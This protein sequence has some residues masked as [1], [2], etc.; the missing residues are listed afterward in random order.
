MRTAG[1][2]ATRG[3]LSAA[4]ALAYSYPQANL[5]EDWHADYG[6]SIDSTLNSYSGLAPAPTLSGTVQHVPIWLGIRTGAALGGGLYNLSLD[7]G[8]TFPI[9]NQTLPGGGTVTV[10]GT[11]MVVTFPA[12]TYT[13]GAVYTSR[14]SSWV[15]RK[16]AYTWVQDSGQPASNDRGPILTARG[17]MN[18]GLNRLGRGCMGKR[19]LST[20]SNGYLVELGT[21]G[22]TLA[23]GTNTPFTVYWVGSFDANIASATPQVMAGL[24]RNAS[25]GRVTF[26]ENVS[27]IYNAAR[28]NDGATNSNQFLSGGTSVGLRQYVFRLEFDG[29]TTFLYRNGTLIDSKA[30]NG[31]AITITQA[32]LFA[33]KRSTLTGNCQ[34]T[35]RRLMAYTTAH[36][37]T[38][39]AQIEANLRAEHDI[40]APKTLNV[41]IEGASLSDISRGDL[42]W[43]NVMQYANDNITVNNIASIGASLNGTMLPRAAAAGAGTFDFYYDS[44]LGSANNIAFLWA[45]ANGLNVVDGSGSL[46]NEKSG[47]T[48][49]VSG[50]HATGWKVIVKTIL[51][52]GTN[53]LFNTKRLDYNDWLRSGASGADYVDDQAS[54]WPYSPGDNVGYDIGDNIH[55]GFQGASWIAYGAEVGYRHFNALAA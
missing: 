25:N 50:R 46:P 47:T 8:S 54:R 12:G 29:T 21:F 22:S 49:W 37:S 35:I 14:V 42:T 44:G 9:Q 43:A 18:N 7:G 5:L 39:A 6:I 10:P 52:H 28:I 48:T 27:S 23:G 34:G 32:C 38:T 4:A 45:E 33:L 16:G 3:M 53:A 55:V 17:R 40:L 24:G 1:P 30:N 2:Y 51:P 11:S 19:A 15:G 41:A 13:T 36:G 31:G 20:A 26:G